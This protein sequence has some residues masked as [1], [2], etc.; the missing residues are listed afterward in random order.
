MCRSCYFKTLGEHFEH[1]SE[2]NTLLNI[3]NKYYEKLVVETYD[4]YID[5]VFNKLYQ[6]KI[7]NLETHKLSSSV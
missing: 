2:E 4:K 7:S 3:Y 5:E 1:K 6:E